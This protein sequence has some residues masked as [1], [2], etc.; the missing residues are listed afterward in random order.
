MTTQ[1]PPRRLY[2]SRNDR[3]LAGVCAGLAQYFGLSVSGLRWL[4]AILILL[5][6]LSLWVYIILWLLIPNEP[7]R[8][9]R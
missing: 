3:V 1:N 4:T 2:R 9:N 6:G 5:G 8:L 7:L